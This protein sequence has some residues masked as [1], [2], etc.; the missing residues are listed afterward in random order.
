MVQAEIEHFVN[1]DDK[2][3]PRFSEVADLE[4]LLYSRCVSSASAVL[5]PIVGVSEGCAAVHCKLAIARMMQSL[6]LV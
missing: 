6:S 4:P 5:K 2:S 3:H 1:P